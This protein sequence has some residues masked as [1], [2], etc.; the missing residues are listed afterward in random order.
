M[1]G[2]SLNTNYYVRA[3]ATNSKGTFYGN[4]ITFL[5][6]SVVS[7]LPIGEGT[8]VN[9]Y[10]IASLANLFWITENSG[11]WDYYFIQ[12]ADINASETATWNN[13]AGWSPIGNETVNFTGK[14]NG[15]NYSIS[16]L[17]IERTISG[18]DLIENIGLFGY[19]FN[20]KIEDMK[21]VN[22]DIKG[23]KYVGGI[24]G[25]SNSSVIDK[26]SS[27]GFIEGSAI[28]GG[29]VG[30]SNNSV[31][32]NCFT[33]CNIT[34]GS[35]SGGIIGLNDESA[36]INCVAE[37]NII[38]Y[39]SIGGLV[40]YNRGGSEINNCYAK[41]IVNGTSSVGG[42]IGYNVESSTISNCY[43]QCSVYGVSQVGGL[44]G[45]SSGGSINFCFSSGTILGDGYIDIGG[46]VGYNI[47]TLVENSFWDSEITPG[48]GGAAGGIAKTTEQMKTESTY[49]DSGWDFERE[50]TNGSDDIWDIDVFNNK[51]YPY[52]SR[53][54]S[55]LPP[56]EGD[57]SEGNPYKIASIEN[58]YWVYQ[59]P[60]RWDYNYIQ[61]ADINAS[62]SSNWF[63]G[64]GWSPIG[65]SL[66]KFTGFYDGQGYNISDLFIDRGEENYIGL[67]GMVMG[68][69]LTGICV[70]NADFTGGGQVGGLVGHSDYSTINNCYTTGS[71]TGSYYAGGM[72]G[73]N[74]NSSMINNS[75]SSVLVSGIGT[76]GGFI[77]MN[78][79]NSEVNNCYSTGS[80]NGT[81]NI[82]GFA[83]YSNN[84]S[85]NYC[86]STGTVTGSTT[87]GGFIGGAV[88]G[89]ISNSFWDIETSEQPT[90]AGGTGKTTAEM[91]TISTFTGAAW[92][93]VGESVN[94]TNDYWNING[95][96][97]SGYPYLSWQTF[98]LSSP[99]GLTITS[100]SSSSQLSWT[101]VSGASSYKVY[102]SEN[103]YAS[104]PT[105][106]SLVTSGVTGTSWTDVNATV[107]K[108]FYVVVAVSA[109]EDENIGKVK[110]EFRK[111]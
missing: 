64:S 70:I 2:L 7:E 46:L 88:S 61:T 91:K 53:Q 6:A 47:G 74:Y 101:A 44:V 32:S 4:Q 40:G 108:K 62:Q 48:V 93:F 3:Y 106:W 63:G 21:I 8:E 25:I 99:S 68:A 92:D 87:T 89:T 82:G 42:L 35:Y 103:P 45:E 16:G 81:G 39:R 26:C 100:T 56:A 43:T 105:G 98:V 34:G 67:F 11:R 33:Q 59:D 97:N 5:S 9:P 18:Y 107:T 80:V 12:T 27:A 58:L 76:V 86:F 14:Y 50:I 13:G 96:N 10:Q 52:F 94:G 69:E 20:A 111:L 104:F 109:K 19:I 77:G 51:G 17:C 24:A 37:S 79:T 30:L 85:M 54:Y 102:S 84:A 66:N 71:V 78:Y 57:G 110:S 49:T 23:G 31:V 28:G 90:S 15:Q 55:F 1:T 36:V 73:Y 65:N 72:A 75:Y 60:I 95:I 29:I 41:C 38:G 83:G 22:A